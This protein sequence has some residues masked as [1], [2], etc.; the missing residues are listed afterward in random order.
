MQIPKEVVLKTELLAGRLQDLLPL[1]ARKTKRAYEA[2]EIALQ[3]EYPRY[4]SN[5]VAKYR[6]ART[7]TDTGRQ[8]LL[9]DVYEPLDLQFGNEPRRPSVSFDEL[10]T[11]GR[12][13][14]VLGSGGSG[15]STL[16]R[17]LFLNT[18][19]GSRSQVP[20]FVELSQLG[21]VLDLSL[22]L[23]ILRSVS[24]LGLNIEEESLRQLLGTGRLVLF[25]DG[26]DEIDPRASPTVA[27]RII[28]LSD[29]YR[30]CP[31][32]VTSRPFGRAFTWP[33][34][35]EM[36]LAPM[37]PQQCRALL[38]RVPF[39]DAKRF[40]FLDR[41]DGLWLDHKEFLGS[42]LLSTLMLMTFGQWG[43][44]SPSSHMFF[45][46]AYYTLFYRHDASKVGFE[47]RTHS[48]LAKDGLAEVTKVIFTQAVADERVRLRDADIEEYV[49]IAKAI[50]PGLDAIPWEAIRDD[51]LTTV[52]ML[53]P[54]GLEYQPVHRSFA[55]YFAAQFVRTLPPEHRR[56]ALR[57]LREN[58]GRQKVLDFLWDIDA[59]MILSDLVLPELEELRLLWSSEGTDDERLAFFTRR[60]EVTVEVAGYL[61]IRHRRLPDFMTWLLRIGLARPAPERLAWEE[62]SL[63]KGGLDFSLTSAKTVERLRE[64]SGKRAEG[65]QRVTLDVVEGTTIRAFLFP[66]STDEA[67]QTL[68]AVRDEIID[69][70]IPAINEVCS[71]YRQLWETVSARTDSRRAA[72]LGIVHRLV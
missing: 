27:N 12:L 36:W 29:R 61:R 56:E 17:Y 55:E 4:A 16:L 26:F 24:S 11:A 63:A 46:Q 9:T 13:L 72:L 43:P 37:T 60:F 8:H 70:A 10:Q 7:I 69:L 52:S 22:E 18:L 57:S 48:G 31:I 35:T 62:R 58:V 15:K 68:Q 53:V 40:A 67:P 44:G 6:L 34:F 2:L 32:V 42:P 54:D 66:S 23:A 47:R 3:Q 19:F 5:A 45:E 21:N 28:E 50:V 14:M 41:L 59:G 64:L 25:L 51:L 20:L 71:C 65:L 30:R 33:S 1:A 49:R 38:T 39:D